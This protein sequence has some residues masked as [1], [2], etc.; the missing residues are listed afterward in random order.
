MKKLRPYQLECN[1]SILEL[2]RS[3]RNPLLI[4]PTGSGKTAI[5][6]KALSDLTRRTGKKALVIVPRK[7]LVSQALKELEGWGLD[8]GAIA[9]KYKEIRRAPIQVATY[10]SLN[11]RDVS[12]FDPD[13]V[14]L[15]EAHISA[16]PES[17]KRWLPRF[18]DPNSSVP[19]LRLYFGERERRVIGVTAT[20][21]RADKSSLGQFFKQED[22]I[23]APGIAQ[24]IRMGYLVRPT[25][26]I[27]PNAVSG[28][29]VFD[30]DYVLKVYRLTDRRPTIIFVP[31]VH[32]A[33]N[34]VDV[35]ARSGI[36]AALV[37]DRT[38]T[39]QRENYFER[40][41][42]EELPVLI[43]CA[44]LREG[45]D[46][47]VATNLILATDPQN[48]TTLD[49]CIGRVL[50]TAT[51][52]DGTKKTTATIWDLTGCVDRLGR[53]EERDYTADDIELPDMTIG[54]VPM[55]QCP[56]PNC[57][58]MSFISA[59]VCACGCEF[60]INKRRIVAPEGDPYALLNRV[61]L[62]HKADYEELLIDAFNE[63]KQP[64]AARVAFYDRYGYTPPV[65]W[66]R[67]FKP[68]PEIE[69]WLRLEDA[70]FSKSGD[71]AQ[72]TLELNLAF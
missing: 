37:V 66:R 6:T 18:V 12:W 15:D 61:E 67:N 68:S 41:K 32:R 29:M 10:Q 17:V 42:A 71:W 28:K 60:D 5:W 26:G 47:P 50:R 16:F 69:D 11:S 33:R 53:P 38:P 62:D 48:V 22:M 55:K 23:F 34:L 64:K 51:Y 49:Q 2:V 3:G 52:K 59:T 14:V 4:A 8:V 58:L 19:E 27:C 39:K 20:P 46:L 57:D 56:S 65:L 30:P 35:F 36:E 24:L 63:G 45:I 25:Y 40:F 44:V 21:R 54:D 43:N 70:K 72:L 31:G 9:D 13:Y 1:R 7:S